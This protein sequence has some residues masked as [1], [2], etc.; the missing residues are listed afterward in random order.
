[1]ANREDSARLKT[2]VKPTTE[3]F[4][5]LENAAL[6]LGASA[7]QVMEAYTEQAKLGLSFKKI[8]RKN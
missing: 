1:M 4:K 8:K 6:K 7:S 2:I 5:R 3:E